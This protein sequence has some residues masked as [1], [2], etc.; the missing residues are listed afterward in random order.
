MHVSEIVTPGTYLAELNSEPVVGSVAVIYSRGRYR[1]AEITKVGPKRVQ[2]E[3][4]TREGGTVSRPSQPKD[5]V[6][7]TAFGDDPKLAGVVRQ[8]D[9]YGRRGGQYLEV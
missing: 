2:V 5:Q 6:W 7:R 8:R 4:V 3:Y 9:A 1:T